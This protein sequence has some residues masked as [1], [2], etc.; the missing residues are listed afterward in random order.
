MIPKKYS[1]IVFH[2]PFKP[3]FQRFSPNVHR[4]NPHRFAPPWRICAVPSRGDSRVPGHIR[5]FRGA[6]EGPWGAMGDQNQ[7]MPWDMP[8]D[9]MMSSFQVWKKLVL[10]ISPYLVDGKIWEIEAHQLRDT[11]FVQARTSDSPIDFMV[12]KVPPC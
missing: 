5:C 11:V 8:R 9:M 3:Y 6:H 7:G 2:L 10:K 4:S 12:T 1:K